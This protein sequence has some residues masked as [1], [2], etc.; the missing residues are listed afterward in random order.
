MPEQEKKKGKRKG[1]SGIGRKQR[2]RTGD[3][4]GQ[5]RKKYYYSILCL[6]IFTNTLI[7]K[8]HKILK[9]LPRYFNLQKKI[10]L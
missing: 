10:K 4:F 2:A 1:K 9:F 5:K 6:F 3:F 8:Q 7:Y